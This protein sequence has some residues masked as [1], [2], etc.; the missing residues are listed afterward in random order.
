MTL[1]VRQLVL[2]A[3]IRDE[4][5]EVGPAEDEEDEN[6][7]ED[8]CQD[9]CLDRETLKEEILTAC[10]HWLREQLRELRER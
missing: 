1:E 3:Q 6:G 7:D 2:R 5:D 4:E 10:Q 9:G 8:G